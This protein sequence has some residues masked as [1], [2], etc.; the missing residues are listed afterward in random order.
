MAWE[1]NGN[2]DLYLSKATM[3]SIHASYTGGQLVNVI[4]QL[5][6]GNYWEAAKAGASTIANTIKMGSI[7]YERK[8][9]LRSWKCKGY[10]NQ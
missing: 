4:I 2:V 3:V 7:N 9:S 1:R 6:L 5:Y 8:Y 10:V